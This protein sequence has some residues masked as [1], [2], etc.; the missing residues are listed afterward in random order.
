MTVA[1]PGFG[2]ATQTIGK[3]ESNSTVALDLETVI[4]EP[5]VVGTRSQSQRPLES[6]VPVEL[7]IGERLR[8]CG[9][10]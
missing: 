4:A 5:I 8:N 3:S 9:H 10:V 1:V 7:V 6:R 2:T